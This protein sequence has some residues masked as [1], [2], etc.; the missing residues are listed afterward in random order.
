MTSDSIPLSHT[1]IAI[2]QQPYAI[3]GHHKIRQTASYKQS[4][5]ENQRI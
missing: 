5:L 1:R 2:K 3:N 4:V